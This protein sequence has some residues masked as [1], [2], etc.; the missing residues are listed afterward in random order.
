MKREYYYRAFHRIR[1]PAPLLRDLL[2]RA[3]GWPRIFP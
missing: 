2:I 1:Y 3:F